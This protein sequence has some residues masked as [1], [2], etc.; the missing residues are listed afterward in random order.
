MLF[1]SHGK[2]NAHLD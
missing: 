1:N 2:I